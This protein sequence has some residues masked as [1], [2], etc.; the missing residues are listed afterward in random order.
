MKLI[1]KDMQSSATGLPASYR[2]WWEVG[3]GYEVYIDI[4]ENRCLLTID[5]PFSQDIT[6]NVAKFLGI[7]TTSENI[8]FNPRSEN[9]LYLSSSID[10]ILLNYTKPDN[11]KSLLAKIE[12]II[13]EHFDNK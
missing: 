6:L 13:N 10:C 2:E 11:Y 12:S 4:S 9:E 7:D 5:S 3:N 1:R 8:K